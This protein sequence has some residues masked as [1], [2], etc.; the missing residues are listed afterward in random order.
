MIDSTTGR[1]ALIAELI[2]DVAKLLSHV[3]ALVA[4]INA[5]CATTVQASTAMLK[6]AAQAERRLSTLSEATTTLAVKHIARMSE[7]MARSTLEV[8]T[9]AMQTAAQDLF[10]TELAGALRQLSLAI[11]S[12][13]AVLNAKHHHGWAHATTATCASLISSALTIY[14]LTP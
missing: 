8:Q 1:E 10:R 13:A 9:R 14:L 11:N 4:A 3:D 5:A 12:Q 6:E 2:G 7:T